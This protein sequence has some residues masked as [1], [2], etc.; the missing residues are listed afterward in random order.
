MRTTQTLRCHLPAVKVEFA[1]FVMHS[2][3]R[4]KTS[5]L[6][7]KLP[8]AHNGGLTE[9]CRK[10]SDFIRYEQRKQQKIEGR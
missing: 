10:V 6:Y 9:R 5:F 7:I 2:D 1:K 8:A 4:L 3:R